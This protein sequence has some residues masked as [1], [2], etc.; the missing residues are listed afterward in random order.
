MDLVINCPL[1]TGPIRNKD[2]LLRLLNN[3][4]KKQTVYYRTRNIR[5]TYPT[6][7]NT[8]N[9]DAGAKGNSKRYR[10]FATGIDSFHENCSVKLAHKSI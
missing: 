6:T 2:Q 7:N 10:F 1:E 5:N 4:N 3:N 9:Y 8:S